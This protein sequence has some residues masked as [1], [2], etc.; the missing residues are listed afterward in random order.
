M[1]SQPTK[2]EV[3]CAVVSNSSLQYSH[4]KINGPHCKMPHN[5]TKTTDFLYRYNNERW[6]Y[7]ANTTQLA[8][9]RTR[10]RRPYRHALYFAANLHVHSKLTSFAST[11]NPPC[12]R[13][14]ATYT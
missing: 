4:E 10:Q 11:T 13:A 5:Q 3:V 8:L 2:R 12:G 9:L 14:P 7:I 6:N 1:Q